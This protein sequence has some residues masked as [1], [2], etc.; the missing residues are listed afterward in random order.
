MVTMTGRAVTVVCHVVWV[1]FFLLLLLQICDIFL[2]I[3]QSAGI[4]YC[5]P[6]AVLHRSLLKPHSRWHKNALLWHYALSHGVQRNHTNHCLAH[7]DSTSHGL[8][9]WNSL[10]WHE[11]SFSFVLSLRRKDTKLTPPFIYSIKCTSLQAS[12]QNCFL[13]S[14]SPSSSPAASRAELIYNL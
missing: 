5:V 9:G 7:S 8:G 3:G 12:I 4:I 13:T 14:F 6:L 11:Q 2:I 10:L 1:D